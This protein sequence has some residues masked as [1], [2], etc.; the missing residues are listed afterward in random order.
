MDRPII[1]TQ[2]NQRSQDFLFSQRATLIA[3]GKLAKVALGSSTIA[4]NLACTPTAPASL[5]VSV[6]MGQIYS[7]A[8]V[9]AT[10]YG[11]LPAD[12]TDMIVKQGINLAATLLTCAAPGTAGYSINYLVEAQYQDVDTTAVV[13][14]YYNGLS[15]PGGNGMAQNTERQGIVGLQLKAG[16]AA[17]TGTQVTPSTDAGWVPLWVV[18]V[19]NGQTQ[20][21]SANIVQA[22]GA[23]FISSL[24]Q[25]IQAG[26]A[27]YAIDTG[28]VNAIAVAL[29]PVPAALT[30]GMQI[31]IK[32]AVTNTSTAVTLNLNGLGAQS[33]SSVFGAPG[34]GSLVAGQ[35]YEFIWSASSVAWMLS[36]NVI[37]ASTPIAYTQFGGVING[38]VTLTAAQSGETFEIVSGTVTLPAVAAGLRFRFIGTG[39]GTGVLAAPAGG[40]NYP[41]G[42]AVI[43]ANTVP[44]TALTTW[45]IISDGTTWLITNTSGQVIT[46]AATANNQAV[47]L[48]QF[49]NGRAVTTNG[50]QPLPGGTLLKFGVTAS[51]AANSSRSV[52]FTT[53]FSTACILI[54]VTPNNMANIAQGQDGVS[55]VSATGF[56]VSNQDNIAHTIN[57]IAIGY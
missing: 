49:T 34:I 16:V 1:Y 18:T 50:T 27:S 42:T 33:V 22:I 7:L 10:P 29:N 23:P 28:A 39:G 31:R 12:T 14:P 24:L 52:V 5:Q 43:S 55:A 30:D 26:T 19:A 17:T 20:I 48:G 44:I 45:E 9:D 6:A 47:N 51:I 53:A 36:S 35:I 56:T 25:T 41:D 46:K 4:E 57:W 37:G 32:V 40:I 21:T 13:L 15:G 54:I 3:I 38:N 8:E 2:E 11:V